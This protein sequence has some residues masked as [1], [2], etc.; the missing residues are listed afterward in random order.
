MNNKKIVYLFTKINKRQKT[1]IHP[2]IINERA[3]K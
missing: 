2:I 3:K 1:K